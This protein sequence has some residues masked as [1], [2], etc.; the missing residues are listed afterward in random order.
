MGPD[1]SKGAVEKRE[2]TMSVA[3]TETEVRRVRL[4]ELIGRP[5]AAQDGQRLGKVKDVIVRLDLEPGHHPPVTGAVVGVDRRELFVPVSLIA[6]LAA[7]P[8]RLSTA[9]LD[10]RAFERRE[11]EVL[12]KRDLL[13][14]RLID[15][16]TARLVRAQDVE[17][18]EHRGWVLVGI[19]ASSRGPIAR[20]LRLPG[21][22]DG[23]R[24][25]SEF[26]P[27]I[28]HDATAKLRAPFSR[29]RRFRPAD[30]A[31]LVEEANRDE[32]DEIL[33]AVGDDKELEADVIEELEPDSQVQVLKE[34]SDDEVADVL[35]HMRPDDAADLLSEFPQE[36]RLPVLEKLPTAT[37]NKIRSLLGF[38]PATAGGM[39]TPDLLALPP[40]ATVQAA[41]A[42]VQVA[43]TVSPEVLLTVYV[44]GDG[45]LLGAISLPALLQA[46]PGAAVGQIA[47]PDPVRVSTDADITEVAVRMTDFNLVTIPVVDAD[48]HLL[49]VITVDDVLEATVPEDWWD[50]VEDVEAAPRPRRKASPATFAHG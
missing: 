47:D 27:L 49:G 29:L 5:V 6:D 11:G 40:D 43:T 12:L 3:N 26:E 21:E 16:A 23:C 4:S 2:M 9:R 7:D 42:Q 31:D 45:R 14:H 30:I 8:L 19:D 22:R 36:R 13:G 50:R 10:L 33:E 38:N 39:M 17:L 24:D 32:S 1:S 48:D 34:R 20:L 46:D 37:Q 28:G 15:V 18:G 44:V 25:W 41:I 35:A